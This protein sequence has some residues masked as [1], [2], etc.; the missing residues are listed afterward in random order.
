MAKVIVCDICKKEDGVL[1]ECRTY[2]SVKGK[3][4]LRIDYCNDCRSKIPDNMTEYKRF[5]AV[6]HGLD[7]DAYL[8]KDY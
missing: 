2:M 3:P 8:K 4:Y 7:K 6:L 5:V 1:K